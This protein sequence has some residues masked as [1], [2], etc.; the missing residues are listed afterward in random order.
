MLFFHDKISKLN[1]AWNRCALTEDDFHRICRKLKITAVEYPLTTNGFYYSV[2]GGHY[3]VVD[4][5]LTGVKKLLVMFHELAHF[6]FH[7]PDHGVTA[8][9]HGV[10]GKTKKEAEADAFALCALV[11]AVWL[12]SRLIHHISEEE[13]IPH[14]ILRDRIDVFERYGI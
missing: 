2:M 8:N 1:I 13:G 10:G 6:L 11:P 12:K 7:T 4:S 9:F 3:I 5:R 14:A